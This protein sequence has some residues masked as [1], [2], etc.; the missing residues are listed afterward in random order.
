M[1]ESDVCLAP[2]ATCSD[3]ERILL[4]TSLMLLLILR[5]AVERTPISSLELDSMVTLKSPSAILSA[6]STIF[7]TGPLMIRATNMPSRIEA[8]IMPT[9][10]LNIIITVRFVLL[11]R[12]SDIAFPFSA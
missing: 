5:N 1:L 4:M 9:M 7:R 12:L 8:S 3:A 10:R 2:E 11:V 6:A